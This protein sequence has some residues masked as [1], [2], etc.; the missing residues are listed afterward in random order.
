MSETKRTM[1]PLKAKAYAEYARVYSETF[2]ALAVKAK[3]VN[4]KN[5]ERIETAAKAA[6][7]AAA[8]ATFVAAGYTPC[9]FEGC[10]R[11]ASPNYTICPAH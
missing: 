6:G 2:R 8:E 7:R 5:R 10:T 1:S 3:G 11:L 4:A 9:M